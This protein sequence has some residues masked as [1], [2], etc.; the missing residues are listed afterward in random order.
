MYWLIIICQTLAIGNICLFQISDDW[1]NHEVYPVVWVSHPTKGYDN[2]VIILGWTGELSIACKSTV[3]YNSAK[4][5]A[6]VTDSVFIT[7][8]VDPKDRRKKA[9]T[10]SHQDGAYRFRRDS[11]EIDDQT[12][13]VLKTDWNI[14]VLPQ[15]AA[16]LCMDECFI[17][18]V[19]LGPDLTYQIDTQ[20][21]YGLLFG[22]YQQG[23]RL[24]PADI[25]NSLH[26]SLKDFNE[27]NEKTFVLQE[28][29]T[30]SP[31]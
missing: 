27:Y 9:V 11:P 28:D 25:Q 2:S 6:G 22:A 8:A 18:M 7:A 26:F 14:P 5:L 23:D 30:F 17:G 19:N 12:S 24:T 13:V 3:E 15:A 29:N 20:T 10:L 4:I 16:G 21:E 31:P 1:E